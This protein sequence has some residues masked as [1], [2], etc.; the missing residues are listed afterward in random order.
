VR[1]VEGDDYI[2][3]EERDEGI[4]LP[5]SMVGNCVVGYEFQ[6]LGDGQKGDRSGHDG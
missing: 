4:G 2:R 3:K 6:E 5:V 1:L